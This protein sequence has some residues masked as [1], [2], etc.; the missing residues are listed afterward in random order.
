MLVLS[1][2]CYAIYVRFSD[3]IPSQTLNCQWWFTYFLCAK[4]Y[5]FLPGSW[6]SSTEQFITRMSADLWT[7][8]PGEYK[9]VFRYGICMDIALYH[10]N[11]LMLYN[12]IYPLNPICT[13]FIRPLAWKIRTPCISSS[14]KEI[15]HQS[16]CMITNCTKVSPNF[17]ELELLS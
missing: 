3:Y 2:V 8:L 17:L 10:A 4:I 1:V 11:L 12:D 7:Y 9:Y 16:S 5:L 15:Q 6:A 13:D 14:K